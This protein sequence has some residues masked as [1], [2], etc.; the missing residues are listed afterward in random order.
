MLSR[1]VRGETCE[2]EA[3]E[4]DVK[5]VEWADKEMVLEIQQHGS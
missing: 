2:S 3:G 4:R 1:H 5:F